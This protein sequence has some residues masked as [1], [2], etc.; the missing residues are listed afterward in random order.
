MA[1]PQSG[2]FDTELVGHLSLAAHYGIRI[3]SDEDSDKLRTLWGYA[4]DA[5]ND[6]DAT[7]TALDRKLGGD[8]ELNK[9]YRYVKLRYPAY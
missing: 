8:A 9:A 3:P 2:S 6:P 1:S 5:G 4:N 7:L